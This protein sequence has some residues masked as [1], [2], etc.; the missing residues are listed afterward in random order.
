MPCGVTYSLSLLDDVTFNHLYPICLM[1]NVQ[2]RT[3]RFSVKAL[4]YSI[5]TTAAAAG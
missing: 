4:S 2:S 3:A 5:T 1:P